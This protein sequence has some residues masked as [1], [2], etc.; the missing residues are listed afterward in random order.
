MI[1]D[2]RDV[3][4]ENDV[5]YYLTVDNDLVRHDKL[6]PE[7]DCKLKILVNSFYP[8]TQEEWEGNIRA[9]AINFL[10]FHG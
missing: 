4:Y 6:I 8:G 9:R 5:A 1:L 2:M 7:D 10:K 3:E